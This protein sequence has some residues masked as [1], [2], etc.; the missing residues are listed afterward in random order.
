VLA[1]TPA[2]F[3]IDLFLTGVLREERPN[4]DSV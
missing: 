4:D 1:L 2:T 3:R